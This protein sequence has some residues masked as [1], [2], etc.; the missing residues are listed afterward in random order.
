MPPFDRSK[1]VT[2]P[3][4]SPAAK[5]AMVSYTATSTRFSIDE[6]M[7]AC[8]SGASATW[9][10]WSESTPMARRSASA[11]AW[12]TPEPE[13]PAAWYTTSAPAS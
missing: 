5:A 2:S 7:Q 3:A 4:N 8:C 1:V 6:R 10:Y 9:K 11:A 13:P 12:K